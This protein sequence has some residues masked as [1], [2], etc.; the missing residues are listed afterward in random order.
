MTHLLTPVRIAGTTCTPLGLG[1]ARL[2]AVWQQRGLREGVATVHAA[3]DL[4]VTLIDTADCYAR[5]ISERLVGRAIG[6]RDDVTVMTKVGLLKTPIAARAATRA[7]GR[8]ASLTGLRRG[9]ESGRCF[10]PDYLRS[11]V[12]ACLSRQSR[13]ALDVLLLHEPTAEDLARPELAETMADL[14]AEGLVRRWGASVRNADAALTAL[15]L[16]GMTW[17]QIPVNAANH[18]IAAAVAD[19]LAGT[20][21]TEKPAI[22]AIGALGDGTLLPAA[23]TVAPAPAAIA[24]L[25]ENAVADD[26]V[27][28][29]LL[30]M[31]TPDHVVA[32]VAALQAGVDETVA[33][34]ILSTVRNG[35]AT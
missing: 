15:D 27:D 7:T 25:T 10:H 26:V 33:A 18:S 13:T 9:P 31:S 12:H 22:I 16:P 14:V 19:H 11:A 32:N 6:D 1:T 3:I 21:S 28:G 24:A 2:G 20:P 5:G 35:P 17:L 8:R 29:V 23:T 30:G 34:A 4:G